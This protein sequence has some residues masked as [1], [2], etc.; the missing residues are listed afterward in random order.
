MKR[1]YKQPRCKSIEFECNNLIAVSTTNHSK[2]EVTTSGNN[3]ES[4]WD[5]GWDNKKM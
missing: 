2:R 4:T 1:E 3:R 5:I